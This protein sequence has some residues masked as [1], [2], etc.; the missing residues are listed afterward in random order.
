MYFIHAT[1][2]YDQAN[3]QNINRLKVFTLPHTDGTAPVHD[4]G[5]QVYTYAAGTDLSSPKDFVLNS[6]GNR[7]Q[8]LR[9][10][11][12]NYISHFREAVSLSELHFYKARLSDAQETH[13]L[14]EMNTK[15]SAIA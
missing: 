10:G 6:S 5:D 15:W 1:W 8:Y 9:V 14:S 7:S 3:G 13:L 2:R 12:Y 4:S 11:G